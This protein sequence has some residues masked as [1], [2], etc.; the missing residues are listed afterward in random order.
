MNFLQFMYK[1]ILDK[2]KIIVKIQ[3]DNKYKIYKNKL[4]KKLMILILLYLIYYLELF[5]YLFLY[6]KI[7]ILVDFNFF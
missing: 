5:S 4:H 7:I 3:N 2:N 6:E 1:N